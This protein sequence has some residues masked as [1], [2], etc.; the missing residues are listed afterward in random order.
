MITCSPAGTIISFYERANPS[1]IDFVVLP[2]RGQRNVPGPW[3]SSGR[4]AD[5]HLLNYLRNTSWGTAPPHPRRSARSQSAASPSECPKHV[6]ELSA[7]TRH[8]LSRPLD[9][10]RAKNTIARAQAART[11]PYFVEL[12][13]KRLVQVE[14]RMKPRVSSQ[15]AANVRIDAT[16]YF[17][18]LAFSPKNS[19][20]TAP[21]RSQAT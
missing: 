15:M 9:P 19:P 13:H 8:Q 12:L 21:S 20:P 4:I 10:R 6:T 16:A 5:C 1:R 2:Y 14:C 7:P 3:K 17:W 18:G 11:E